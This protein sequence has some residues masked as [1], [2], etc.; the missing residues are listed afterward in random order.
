MILLCVKRGGV[1]NTQIIH[2]PD[3][4]QPEHLP[5][6]RIRRQQGYL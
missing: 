2:T 4:V 3:E 1:K 5:T 6:F